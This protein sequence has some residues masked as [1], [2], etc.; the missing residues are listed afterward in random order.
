MGSCCCAKAEVDHRLAQL[1]PSLLLKV[2]QEFYQTD[3]ASVTV[4]WV[5]REILGVSY[6]VIFLESSSSYIT[7]ELI[8]L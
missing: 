3:S 4:V 2:P 1:P 5:G 6:S 8:T 7:V